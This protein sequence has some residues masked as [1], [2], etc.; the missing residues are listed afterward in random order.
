MVETI[1]TGTQPSD[2]TN[3]LA[4]PKYGRDVI[5]RDTP[6]SQI[7]LHLTLRGIPNLTEEIDLGSVSN[8]PIA[9]GGFSDIFGAQ[10]RNGTSVVIKL[11]RIV[12]DDP[13]NADLQ[14]A[15]RGVY[16]WSKCRHPNIHEFLGFV[17]FYDRIGM[18]STWESNGNVRNYLQCGDLPAADRLRLCVEISEGVS[19]LHQAGIVRDAHFN[20]NQLFTLQCQVHG[21]IK[22]NNVLISWDGTA[23]L[24]DFDDAEL[25]ERSLVFRMTGKLALSL[26]WA[27]P[28]LVLGKVSR[29][30]RESDVYSLGMVYP[31]FSTIYTYFAKAHAP[32]YTRKSL[33]GEV[34]SSKLPWAHIQ[35]DVMIIGA[36]LRKETP[37]RTSEILGDHL[38]S[39]LTGCWRSEPQARPGSGYVLDTLTFGVLP[40][41]YG[42]SGDVYRGRLLDSTV[43]CVK[44]PR[45]S[46]DAFRSARNQVYASR[47]IH[48]WNKCNHIHVLPLLGLAIFRGRIAILSPWIQNGTLREYLKKNSDVDR[49]R[50]STQICDGV[51]YL[52]SIDII[53]GDLKG[54]NVLISEDGNALLTDFGSADLQN[55]TITFTQLMDQTGWTMRWGAPELLQEI[56]L[57]S[58]ESDVYALGMTI[59]VGIASTLEHFVALLTFE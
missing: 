8:Y 33:I 1:A 34:M 47:E 53:H 31:S 40:S 23:V 56:L 22:G 26:R 38:W 58:K 27:A 20:D 7:L 3:A 12:S 18:V 59:I 5:T 32:D 9:T 6:I 44:V 48:T 14:I 13:S 39:I 11:P 2:Y 21:D 52:H 4:N 25:G 15:S 10:R 19:Y 37:P 41:R 50:L 51:A 35:G 55:R 43:V 36:I 46:E 42:G 28:E 30:S 54:D 24:T 16:N 45:I 17:I 49:C 29:K 57:P